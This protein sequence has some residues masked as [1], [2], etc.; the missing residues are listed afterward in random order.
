MEYFVEYYPNA[1]E[2]EQVVEVSRSEFIKIIK[3]HKE[4]GLPTSIDFDALSIFENGRDAEHL[5][6]R[7]EYGIYYYG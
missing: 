6:I 2:G 7:D 5:T 4:R 3:C 1:D